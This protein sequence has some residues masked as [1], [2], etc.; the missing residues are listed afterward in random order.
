MTSGHEPVLTADAMHYLQPERGGV[1][2]DCTVGLGGH[3]RAL[4]ERGATRVIGVDRD[5]NALATA[6]VALEEWRDRVEL[7]HADYRDLDQVLDR[8]GVL[9]VDGALADLGV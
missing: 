4:L 6:R 7:F 9:L 5:P 1:F 3:T 8:A 2:L